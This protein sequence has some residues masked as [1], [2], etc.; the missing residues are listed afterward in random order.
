MSPHL[1]NNH[2]PPPTGGLISWQLARQS[3]NSSALIMHVYYKGRHGVGI[4][5][6]LL[7]PSLPYPDPH[8]LSYWLK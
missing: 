2:N 1:I 6:V 7:N 3:D 8:P 5:M 4:I